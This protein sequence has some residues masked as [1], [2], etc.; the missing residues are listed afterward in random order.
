MD[1]VVRVLK[2]RRK[3]AQ[4]NAC[5]RSAFAASTPHVSGNSGEQQ[6]GN[7]RFSLNLPQ[8]R[9]VA[10]AR[11]YFRAADKMRWSGDDDPQ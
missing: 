10:Y 3:P 6:R 4:R 9:A 7:S 11:H 2:R 1:P 5:A 8:Q